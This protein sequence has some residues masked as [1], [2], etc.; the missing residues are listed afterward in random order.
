MPLQ[1]HHTTHPISAAPTGHYLKATGQFVQ[2]TG[3][4]LLHTA[5]SKFVCREVD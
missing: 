3:L 5:S 1:L 2:N 4:R